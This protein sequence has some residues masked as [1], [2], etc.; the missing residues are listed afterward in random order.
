[1]K[2]ILCILPKMTEG[3]AE[4]FALTFLNFYDRSKYQVVLALARREGKYE[5]EIPADVEVIGLRSLSSI[6]K[7]FAPLGPFRYISSLTNLI[8]RIQPDAIISF[9][10]LLNGAVALSAHLSKCNAPTLIVEA[11]NESL[12]NSRR[13]F[14]QKWTRIL[15]LRIT[16]PLATRVI[17]VSEDL[18]NDLY[19]NFSLPK[20][21][22]KTIHYGVDLEGIRALSREEVSQPWLSEKRGHKTVVACGRLVDQ[23]GFKFLVEAM[24]KLPRTIKLVLVGDGENKD[25]LISQIQALQLEEQ[26][27]LVGYDRN[28]YKYIAKAN[29]FCMPSLWE[30]LPIVLLESLSLGVPILASDCPSGPKD[31]L[32]DNRYGILVP[33]GDSNALAEAMQR[34][35]ADQQLCEKLGSLALERSQDFSAAKSVNAYCELIESLA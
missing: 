8:Q 35:L 1:M 28:P 13:S 9:G 27:S 24:A 31:I 15:F 3:G 11:V 22:M 25:T 2:K 12:E 5:C 19:V 4:R 21:K 7:W 20:A 32:Q 10:S 29:L 6:V 30:G 17:T 23:K 18:E 16:Y 33:P 34:I 26:I 14:F